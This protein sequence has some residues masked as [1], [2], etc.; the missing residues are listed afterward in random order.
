M[1]IILPLLVVTSLGA[2]VSQMLLNALGIRSYAITLSL[3]VLLVLGVL[4][5][6][7]PVVVELWFGLFRK[8]MIGE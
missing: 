7:A 4:L 2:F 3:R 1:L 5:F 6:S 8:T